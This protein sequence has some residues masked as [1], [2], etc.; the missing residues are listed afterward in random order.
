MLV[1]EVVNH[2]DIRPIQIAEEVNPSGKRN[3]M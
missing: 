3:N 2:T 1:A